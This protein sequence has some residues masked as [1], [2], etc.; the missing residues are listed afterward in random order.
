MSCS[1]LLPW[2][3]RA[4]SVAHSLRVAGGLA[5][6]AACLGAPLVQAQALRPGLWEF[7]GQHSQLRQSSGQTVDMQKINQQLETQLRGMEPS[8]RRMLEENLRSAGVVVDKG[9][10]QQLCV[11]PG[12][13]QLARLAELQQESCTFTL[14]ER[15]ADFVRGKL[16]CNEPPGQG[17]YVSTVI[18]PERLSNRTELKTPQGQLIITASAQWMGADCGGAPDV[19]RQRQQERSLFGGAGAK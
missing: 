14:Q 3:P 17:S 7:E 1:L 19:G 6:G 4:A 10:S 13:A 18:T 12:Q 8:V 2:L 16:Q 11:Q 9:R 15:G 5:V